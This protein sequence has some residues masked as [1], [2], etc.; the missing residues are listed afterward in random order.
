MFI[1]FTSLP[2]ALVAAVYTYTVTQSVWLTLGAYSGTGS[3]CVLLL[4]LMVFVQADEKECD[5]E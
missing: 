3:A 1:A 4:A 2:P 5:L